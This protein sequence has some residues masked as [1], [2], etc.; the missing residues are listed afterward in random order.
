MPTNIRVDMSL[1]DS[2]GSSEHSLGG[3]LNSWTRLRKPVGRFL[4]LPKN[5]IRWRELVG[6]PRVDPI[7]L[8]A[9][10]PFLSAPGANPHPQTAGDRVEGQAQERSSLAIQHPSQPSRPPE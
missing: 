8:L 10:F 4:S 9:R 3:M 6:Y 7:S 1:G 2:R 5:A